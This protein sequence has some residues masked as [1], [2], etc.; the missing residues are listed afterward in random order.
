ML[1]QDYEIAHKKTDK[2]LVGYI[3][4]R[5][6]I[7]DIPSKIDIINQQCKDF[8]LGPPIAVI[9]YGVYSDGGGDIDLC[10]PI[11]ETIELDNINT[12]FLET[13]EVLFKIHKG[14]LESITETF[15]HLSTYFNLHGIPGTGW[16]R[17][18]FHK[19]N[20]ENPDENEI[21]MQ[22]GIHQWD[23][24]LEGNLDRVLGEE[25]RKEVMRD[26]ETLFTIESSNDER[27]QWIKMMLNRLDGVANDY[28]KYDILSCCAHDFSKK[29]INTLRSIYNKTSDIDEVLKEMHKDYAWYEDPLRKESIIHVT[30]IPYN[31]E[32]YEKAETLEEKKKNYCHCP[33]VRNHFN[34][35]ISPTFCNCSAGWYR[36]QWEGILGK[37]VRIKI[38][39]SLVNGDDK[40][41]FAISLPSY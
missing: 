31:P 40:C 12:K 36:Q 8:A 6:E 17:L 26:R 4:F 27:A 20:K 38:I 25:V 33:I 2:I 32:G 30:K 37:P 28:E 10:I 19:Y 18:V 3:N 39:E 9:D 11:K 15:Q 13:K 24:R 21:E 29:R 22:C 5:G 1:L 34:E 35:G 7:K 23:K 16:L 14:S 41:K